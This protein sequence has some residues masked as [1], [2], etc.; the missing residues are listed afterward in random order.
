M[1]Y[2]PNCGT[3]VGEEMDFCPNCGTSLKRELAPEFTEKVK[4]ADKTSKRAERISEKMEKLAEKIGERGKEIGETMSEQG[5][6]IGERVSERT[7]RAERKENH[8]KDEEF[9][10]TERHEK[11][12]FSFI[13]P[14]TGG[15]ILIFLGLLFYFQVAGNVGRD[16]AI[17][18]FLVVIGAVIIAVALY[19][20]MVAAR[21]H[22]T[23]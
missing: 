6:E 11:R 23:T 5:K 19:A 12:E 10:K 7:R 18:S 13:G 16:V 14:L 4:V 17:A 9:E 8:E 20:V 15:L 2:C 21:R 3:E 1:P 22:P